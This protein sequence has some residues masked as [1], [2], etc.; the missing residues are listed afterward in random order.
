VRQGAGRR[1]DAV[2]LVQ[3]LAPFAPHIA[4]ELWERLGQPG[5]VHRA[6]WPGHD[7]ALAANDLVTI[8]V[9]V[10]GRL[11]ATFQ[12]EA[13]TSADELGRLALAQP[14]VDEFLAGRPVRKVIPVP[15]RLVNLVV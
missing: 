7:A 3:L 6:P 11:R 13:G 8:A 15:D 5:S 10:N 4:E 14:R 9:Q 2:T 1:I 12:C